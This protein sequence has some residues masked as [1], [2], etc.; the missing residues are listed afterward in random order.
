MFSSATTPDIKDVE[1]DSKDLKPKVV[2]QH[3]AG[4]IVYHDEKQDLYLSHCVQRVYISS[5]YGEFELYDGSGR[6]LCKS[7]KGR[8]HLLKKDLKDDAIQVWHD[9]RSLCP[10]STQI[11]QEFQVKDP[12][13]DCNNVPLFIRLVDAPPYTSE[14]GA[15]IHIPV[16]YNVTNVWD[17]VAKKLRY[18]SK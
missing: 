4:T 11:R 13:L 18:V 8:L 16:F 5:Y 17:P 7:T 1:E 12:G 15:I 14:R 3:L 2:T 9:A 6:M 10:E